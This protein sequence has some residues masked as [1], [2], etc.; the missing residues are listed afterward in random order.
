MPTILIGADPEVFVKNPNSGQF[1]SAHGMIKGTKEEPFKVRSGAVQVDGTALEFNI[2]PASTVLQF[3]GNIREVFTQMQMM[4]PGYNVVIEPT[5]VFEQGYFDNEIPSD[6]KALGCTPDFNGWTLGQNIPPDNSRPMRTGAGHIHIGW[7]DDADVYDDEH[8]QKCA[9]MARQMD[10]YLGIH[11]LM[12]DPDSQRRTM[13]GKAGCFRPKPYGMEYR[14]LSNAWL[15]SPFLM[16]WVYKTA[17]LGAERFLEG[18]RAEDRWGDLAQTIINHNQLGWAN[19]HDI[20]IPGL[21]LPPATR[22]AA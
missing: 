13:Y 3:V 21:A 6:A 11:S 12:W 14:T 15:K 10:Y 20:S 16:A 1:V 22:K 17:V 4:V 7:T 19:D 5:A 9:Q 2:D 18:E 8:F